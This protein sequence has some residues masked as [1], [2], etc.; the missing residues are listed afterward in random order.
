[1]RMPVFSLFFVLY[2]SAVAQ[3]PIP[4]SAPLSIATFAGADPAADPLIAIE[5]GRGIAIDP[6]GNVFVADTARHR[7]LRI[8]PSGQLALFAGTG[9]PGFFGDDGPATAAQ[10]NS[11]YGLAADSSGNL[12]IADL[13]NGRIRRVGADG[14]IH[15]IAGGGTV[16]VTSAG[17][18]DA[19]QALLKAPRNVARD[20]AGNLYISDFADHRVLRLGTDGRLVSIA[21][22]GIRGLAIEVGPAATTPLSFPAGL[23]TDASGSLWI[24]DSGNHAIRRVAGSVMVTVPVP[25]DFVN[26]PTAVA[27][28]TSGNLFVA[29]AGYDQGVRVSASGAATVI[30]RPAR[31]LALDATGNVFVVAGSLVRRYDPSGSVVAIAGGTEQFRGDGGPASQAWFD[32]PQD[33][34]ADHGRTFYIADTRNN[35]IRRVSP[36]GVVSTA[37]SGLAAPEGIVVDRAGNLFIADTGNHRVRRLSPDGQMAV[38]AGT[39]VAGFNGEAVDARDAQLSFP[40]SLAIDIDGTLLIAD[41][42]NHRI[43]RLTTS[44]YIMTI[45]GAGERGFGGDGAGAFLAK[46]DSPRALTVDR[47]GNLYFSDSGTHRIRCISAQG[48]IRTVAA[49]LLHPSGLAVDDD[50]TVYVSDT[51]N[52]RLLRVIPNGVPELLAG[53]GVRGFANDPGPALT[54]QF[55]EPAGLLLDSTGALY[56][57]DRRNHRIRRVTAQVVSSVV[58]T[59]PPT[60]PPPA[61]EPAAATVQVRALHSASLTPTSLAPGLLLTIEGTGIGPTRPQSGTLSTSGALETTLGDV[62]VLFNGVAAP[63]IYVQQN[64]L[65]VQVPYGLAPGVEATVEILREGKLRARV[66]LPVVATAPGVFTSA[67][68]EG[69]ASAI[70]EDGTLHGET[71]PVRRGDVLTLFATGSG[72]VNPTLSEGRIADTAITPVAPVSVTLAGLPAEVVSANVAVT[73]PGV[74]QLKIRVPAALNAGSQELLVRVGDAISQRGVAIWVK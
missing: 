69:P 12:Y 29:S 8:S 31:D 10:L 44:G 65:N 38:I 60:P 14:R 7:V 32:S 63:L 13:D 73:S 15:T 40:T 9:A 42:G 2:S 46:L 26:L 36:T 21:G 64:L 57:A 3:P 45:A 37:A 18:V 25:N 23:F 70:L 28:D 16:P 34:K 39:G 41:T 53:T 50:G 52:H 27:V 74:L 54:A 48:A 68:G 1:M 55:N 72:A 4:P 51:G 61:S 17:A 71:N 49:A 59:P 67:G 56:V 62:Q 22:T 5:D 33:I 24:A 6:S 19:L 30:T 11:P 35:R 58:P 47:H 20:T 43:R 66:S